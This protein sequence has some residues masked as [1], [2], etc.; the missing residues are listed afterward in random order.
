MVGGALLQL[1]CIANW[2]GPPHV[3][4]EPITNEEWQEVCVED[5]SIAGEVE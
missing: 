1:F 2:T 5:L 4:I 3:S